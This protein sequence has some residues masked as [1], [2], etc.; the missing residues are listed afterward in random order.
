[1]KRQPPDNP[2]PQHQ[3]L[4]SV[5]ENRPRCHGSVIVAARAD[6]QVSLGQPAPAFSAIYDFNPKIPSKIKFL[7]LNIEKELDR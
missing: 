4:V 6:Y 1:M 7:F 3:R 5:L 2:E